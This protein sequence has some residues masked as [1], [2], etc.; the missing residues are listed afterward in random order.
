M[1]GQSQSMPMGGRASELPLHFLVLRA[2]VV[3]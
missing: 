2:A 1:V 3:G